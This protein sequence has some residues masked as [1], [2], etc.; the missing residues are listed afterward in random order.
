VAPTFESARRCT[1]REEAGGL[2]V[3]A[4]TKAPFTY[5]D[6]C[7]ERGPH[8]GYDPAATQAAKEAVEAFLKK[9][10]KLD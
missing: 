1:I 6:A 8:L 10:F 2:L 3:N 9:V 7:V 5:A 4:D